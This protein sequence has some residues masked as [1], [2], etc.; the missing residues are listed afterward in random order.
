MT[1]ATQPPLTV[2]VQ[3]GIAT[4]KSTVARMLAARG[5]DYVD[6]DVLA[7]EELRTQ[8]ARDAVRGQFGDDV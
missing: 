6:C 7:H 4:G 2:L 1:Q 3:G 8:A 5:A